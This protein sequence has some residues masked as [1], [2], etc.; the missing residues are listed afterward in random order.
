M[1]NLTFN[2]I[3]FVLFSLVILS[4]GYFSK[5]F[6]AQKKAN[7]E[8][9]F[10]LGGKTI[11]EFVG[12]G[13]I[14]ATGYSGWGF[15][16]SPGS[17]YQFGT[18]EVLANFLFA[19]AITFGTLFFANFM[20]KRA[21]ASGGMTI[22]EYIANSHQGED[23]TRKLVQ[24]IAG[25]TT[26]IFLSIYMVGQ[27]RAIGFV[28]AKWLGVNE[29]VMAIAFILIITIFTIQGG[30]L[31]VALTDTIMCMGMI[32]ATLVISFVIFKDISLPE[33]VT[34]LGQIDPKLI[35]PTSSAPYGQGP[36]SVFLVFV[37]ALLFTTTLPYMSVRFL[38]FKKDIKIHKLALYLVP[39]GLVLSIIPVVGL[40]MRIKNPGLKIPD[41]VMPIFLNTYLH[42][43][44]ASATTLFIL[45]AMLSTVSSV[46]QTQ[47]AAL[48]Y[49]I[50]GQWGK[51]KIKDPQMLNK[52]A[53]VFTSILCIILS[54]FAPQSMLNQISYLGTGGIIAMF[55]GPILM[56]RFKHASLNSCLLSMLAG[57]SSH[58]YFVSVLQL[59]WVESPIYSSLI[60][61]G[62]YL[63]LNF[64]EEKSRITVED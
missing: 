32:L 1:I 59:G 64:L 2:W 10:L 52:L 45:F 47:A 9:G 50:L 36:S 62:L 31:A 40:Y 44:V 49:D 7:Q 48:S 28:G 6:L 8:E 34:S 5:R 18:I 43:K 38:S 33:M 21:Q 14:I 13:T 54:F 29:M 46:L 16:G 23:L 3:I 25:L 30:F 11:G 19:P 35:N 42:P 51:D 57:F 12:A 39:M 61:M 27:I 63:V 60:N 4:V 53:V 17:A 55:S 56:N 22:P 15:I 24:S 37:Y 41:Q 26:F 58:L 20:R